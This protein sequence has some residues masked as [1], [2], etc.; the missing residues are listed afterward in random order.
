MAE[1]LSAFRHAVRC[2]RRVLQA[3]ETLSDG[4]GFDYMMAVKRCQRAFGL[5]PEER[6]N[7]AEWAYWS[8][9]WH[10]IYRWGNA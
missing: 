6:W 1:R 3:D 9:L 10:A 5:D 4:S 8:R 2:Y 7:R